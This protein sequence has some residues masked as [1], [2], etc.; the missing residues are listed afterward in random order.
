MAEAT[1]SLSFRDLTLE[2]ATRKYQGIQNVRDWPTETEIATA[3]WAG[4]T[5]AEI[6]EA[7]IYL[8]DA[9]AIVNSGYKRVLSAHPWDALT[10]RT[11]LTGWASN[12]ETAVGA[13][14]YD[15]TSSTVTVDAAMFYPSMVG[16]TITFGT[17]ETIWTIDGYTSSTVITVIGDA[18]GEAAAQEITVNATGFQRLPDDFAGHM[19]DEKI[20]LAPGS[21]GPFLEERP[22]DIIMG[23]RG[24]EDLTREHPWIYGL[25][26]VQVSGNTRWNVCFWPGFG[27]DAD[28]YIRYRRQ[29][30]ELT[31]SGSPEA[32]DYPLGGGNFATAIREACMMLAEEDRG[33]TKGPAHE[34]Y[35]TTLKDAIA[36]DARNKSSNLGYNG[37]NSDEASIPWPRHEAGIR[38]YS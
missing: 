19:V 25:E 29:I 30:S 38:T 6:D 35:Y 21:S 13:P 7:E 4:H 24:R 17:S 18:S 1:G 23:F 26:P 11:T 15:G 22:M 10:A 2:V 37:D 28:L 16:Q 20:Y 5:T 34:T 3:T 36:Q 12:T 14:T 8:T 32:T 33:Y 27:T 31:S 9:K